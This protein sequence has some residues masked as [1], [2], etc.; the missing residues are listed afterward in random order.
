MLE[1]EDVEAAPHEASNNG[2]I[3]DKFLQLLDYR[4]LLKELELQ[5]SPAAR[6]LLRRQQAG[7]DYR[8]WAKRERE[9]TDNWVDVTM[10]RIRQKAGALAR[11]YN[12]L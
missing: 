8:A 6:E 11:R 9:R 4:K 1:W 5:L 10:F 2:D 7:E 3:E 12:R